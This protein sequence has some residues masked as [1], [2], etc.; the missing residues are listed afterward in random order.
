TFEQISDD[1][2]RDA[3]A[4]AHG[5]YGSWRTSD[6]TQ[7]TD[8]LRRTAQLIR[9]RGSDLADLLTL[10]VGKPGP[11]AN[12][13]VQLAARIFEYYADHAAAF[14]ADE[15]L[16][17]A[18][19]GTAIVRTEATGALVGVMPWNYPYY[20]VARF[21]APNLALGNTIVLKHALNC[22]QSALAIQKVLHDA[23]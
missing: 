19:P 4:R 9:D 21:A 20:Q 17:I 11:E 8:V 23:G 14:L 10:E 18:G 12:G 1:E 3:V 15:E 13:E 22:P 7:R 5:A 16:D 6:L 2:M